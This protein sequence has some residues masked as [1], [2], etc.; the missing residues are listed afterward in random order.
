MN[1]RRPRIKNEGH[2]AFIRQLPCVC[3][4][5]NLETEAAHIRMSAPW[6]GKRS[7]G[8][9]EKPSDYWTI[10]LCGRHHREQHAMNERDF[11]KSQG[12]DPIIVAMALF[13]SSGD[14]VSCEE[15]IRHRGNCD[16]AEPSFS[17]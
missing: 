5:N 2:L 13:V 6:Y 16:Y 7:T 4:G 15:I 9:Q 11:W 10:P 12:I 3:C 1:F 17:A 14:F 8:G